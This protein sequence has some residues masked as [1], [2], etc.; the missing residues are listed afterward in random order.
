MRIAVSKTGAA[1]ASSRIASS[2]G[3]SAA[4]TRPVMAVIVAGE[5]LTPNSSARI[6]P[7]RFRDRNCPYH[8]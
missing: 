7:V 5:T 8:K 1:A 3:P 6:C 2:A 4:A